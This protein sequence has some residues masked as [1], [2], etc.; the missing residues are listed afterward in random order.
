MYCSTM[1][2]GGLRTEHASETSSNADDVS[3]CHFRL[4]KVLQAQGRLPD[5]FPKNKH[6]EIHDGGLYLQRATGGNAITLF[7]FQQNRLNALF[8]T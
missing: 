2:C 4:V 6:V 5:V 1:Y 8:Y 3:K 7:F